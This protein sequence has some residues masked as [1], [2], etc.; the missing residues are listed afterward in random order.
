MKI[1]IKQGLTYP[2][3]DPGAPLK[4]V[5]GVLFFFFWFL[6][7]L[8]T[9]CMAG[10]AVE[11]MRQSSDGND[12]TMP[13]WD[14]FGNY[15]LKG[16]W[17]FLIWLGYMLV[18]IGLSIFGLGSALISLFAGFGHGGAAGVKI[19]LLAGGLGVSGIIGLT[20][21]ALMIAMSFILPAAIARLAR[22][23]SVGE[24]FNVPAV[25]GDIMVAPL[26]Y[27]GIYLLTAVLGMGLGFVFSL[28][29]YLGQLLVAFYIC[30]VNA[31]LMG[32]Y[33]RAYLA[34]I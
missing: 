21:I 8:P 30:M 28:I 18:P 20:G 16:F 14:Q 32:Q 11:A 13:S 2:F 22:T 29:P 17:A 1:D 23:G 6:L 5:V 25:F 10:F 33:S 7:G 26:A 4:W 9:L 24:G 27:L 15:G 12:E 19:G 31:N 3:R 34:S